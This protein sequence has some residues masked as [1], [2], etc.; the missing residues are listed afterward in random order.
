MQSKVSMVMTCYNKEKYIDKMFDSIIAQE[1]DNLELILVNNGSVDATRAIISEYEQKFYKRGFEVLVIN[2]ENNGVCSAVKDGLQ[3]I[4]GKYICLVDADDILDSKYISVMASW[5]EQ[6][7]NYDYCVCGAVGYYQKGHEIIESGL[8][9]NVYY[10]DE[11]NIERFIMGSSLVT[12]WIYMLRS[13]YFRRCGIVESF[14]TETMGVQEPAYV[15]PILAY[16]GKFKYFAL[17]LYKY[18]LV[19]DGF[20]HS[21]KTFEQIK[22][23]YYEYDRL[24]R[25][26][27]AY[28][29][30]D[31]MNEDRKKRLS[32]VSAIKKY[33]TIYRYALE[34]EDGCNF[35]TEL[36]QKLTNIIN[37]F[38]NFHEPISI[39][40][41]KG[42]VALL[43]QILV[44]VLTGKSK[45]LTYEIT[46]RVIYYGAMGKNAIRLLP[47]LKG[48]V[49]EPTLLWDIKGDGDIVKKPDFDS[50]CKDDILLL[51][52][53]G[54]FDDV[55][56]NAKK[57]GCLVLNF[58]EAASVLMPYMYPQFLSLYT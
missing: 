12:V 48:T 52:L 35:Y 43:Y 3:K 34:R 19:D 33:I 53:K 26:A 2:R 5:L 9:D 10:E 24:N 40:Q 32:D 21:Q 25:I 28:L 44:D 46:G 55:Y 58:S 45:R 38:F 57:T 13:E 41:I 15:L 51:F 31:V 7:N 16:G 54:N 50:L 23:Y 11:Y 4:T 14:F 56:D 20:Y 8:Y 37:T 47:E 6:N 42:N 22:Q 39:Y 17:S 29:P 27:M 30:I 18:N 36:L 49:L 1:W